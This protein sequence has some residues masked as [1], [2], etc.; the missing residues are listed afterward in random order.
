MKKKNP[1]DETIYMKT[2]I[3]MISPEKRPDFIVSMLP[4]SF[5]EKMLDMILGHRDY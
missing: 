4:F 2:P 5:F 1:V 3:V